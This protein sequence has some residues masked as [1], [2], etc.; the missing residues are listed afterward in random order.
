MKRPSFQFYPA[1]WR[2]NA[3][4]RRCSWA[5]RGAWIDV[6]GLLHDSDEYG[7]LRWPL[8]EISQA[9]G[10]PLSLIKELE[11]K[12]VLKGSDKV[13]TDPFTYTPVS[14]RKAGP[15]VVLI[16][17]QEGP[18]WYCSRMV[19]DEYVRQKKANNELFKDSPNYTPNI[20]PKP[21]IGEDKGAA[22]MPPKSDLPTSTST[23]SITTNTSISSELA[24]L[25]SV[26]NSAE[27]RDASGRNV[28]IAVLLRSLAIKPFTAMHPNAIEW[29]GNPAITDD[30]L[31]S[32]V[33][34]AR[35][36][37]PTSDHIS[38]EYIKPI[39]EQLLT[40]QKTPKEP[41]DSWWASDAGIDRKG[42]ELGMQARPT[43]NYAA[44]K[45]RIFQELRNRKAQ[46]A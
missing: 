31:R 38:P 15:T 21:P 11:T 43:E 22:P 7:V 1:D 36:Y 25:E 29:A 30:I 23:S 4:L 32:A 34:T 2:N 13:I 44:Y 17:A 33:E 20:S 28:Q 35:Q 18:I 42:R 41:Q 37:K 24:V 10:C 8:K 6:M 39:I 45:D 19:R 16:P 26:D 46:L 40:P 12:G 14:G 5:S 9:V 27:R 3:K